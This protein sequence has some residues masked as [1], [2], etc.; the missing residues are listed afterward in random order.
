MN[1]IYWDHDIPRLFEK[2][3]I[4]QPDFKIKTIADITDDMYGS[5]PC[6]LGDSTIEDPVY[7]VDKFTMEKTAPYLPNSIDIMAVGN[8]P[9]E[10]PRD[11][12][13]YF[14]QQLI[15]HVLKDIIDGDSTIIEKATIIKNGVLNEHYAYMRD[16]V[17]EEV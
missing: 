1:G 11:A 12:S 5:I 7:G 10:L 16:Y 6:N 8:L 13:R 2:E 17:G 14:G 15:K 9:N 4:N 3:A